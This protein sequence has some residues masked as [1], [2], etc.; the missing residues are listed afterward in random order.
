MHLLEGSGDML[1]NIKI[2]YNHNDM[3]H[4]SSCDPDTVCKWNIPV[5]CVYCTQ[6]ELWFESCFYLMDVLESTTACCEACVEDVVMTTV[7]NDLQV[8][9]A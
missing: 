5:Y 8:T 9:T 7:A 3:G 6:F 1:F 2:Q 4:N